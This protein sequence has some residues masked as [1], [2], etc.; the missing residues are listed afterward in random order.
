MAEPTGVLEGTT[1]HQLLSDDETR[2]LN[3]IDELRSQGVGKLLGEEGLPQ[4]IVCGDQSSGK[5]SVL[6]ALTRVR[7]P[8]KSSI[9]TTFPTELRLRREPE[10][11]ISCR[12]KAAA[13]RTSEEKERLARF[14]ESFDSPEKFPE[15]ITAAR[16]CMSESTQGNANAFF[17]DVLEVEVVGPKLAPLTIVDLPGLIHYRSTSSGD[18]DINLVTK[19]V[20]DYMKQSN[21]IILAVVSAHNDINNQIVLKHIKDIVPE[22]NRTLGIITKP[23]ELP[24][25]SEKEEEYLEYAR[26]NP[27]KFHYGWHVVRNRTYEEQASS[28]EERDAKEMNFFRDSNWNSLPRRE[29]GLG[30][31]GLRQKLSKMLLD[32]INL[33]LPSIVERLE[34]DLERSEGDLNRLGEPRS[35]T[36]DQKNYLS[37][38]SDTF[39]DYV[40]DALDGRYHRRSFFGDPFSPEGLEKRLRA[41]IRNLNDEF[42]SRM[43]TQGH[44]WHVVEE[45]EMLSESFRS[46]NLDHPNIISK[47]EFLADI[48]DALA[49]HERGNELPGLSNPLLVGSLFQQQSEP[50]ESIATAHLD[51][52]WEAVNEFLETLLSHLT[53][54]RTCNQLLI[55]VIDPAME[56]KRQVLRSKLQE[57]LVPHKHNPINV[58]PLFAHKIWSAK[59]E[60]ITRSVVEVVRQEYEGKES[61]GSLLSVDEMIGKIAAAD[62]PVDDKHGSN[63]TF[64]FMQAYY[65]MTILIFINN[66][67]S[68]AVE[69]CL[70]TK[71]PKIF[72]ST[73]IREMNDEKLELVASESRETRSEREHVAERVK[74]LQKGLQTLKQVHPG[75]RANRQTAKVTQRAQAQSSNKHDSTHRDL[76]ARGTSRP[77]KAPPAQLPTRMA[78]PSPPKPTSNQGSVKSPKPS[79]IGASGSPDG[80]LVGASS[81]KKPT[82]N[83][84]GIPPSGNR[85]PFAE[86]A[87]LG[88]TPFGTPSETTATRGLPFTGLGQT[89]TAGGFGTSGPFSTAGGFGQT[90]TLGRT[91]L[92]GASNGTTAGRGSPFEGFSQAFQ[93]PSPTPSGGLFGGSSQPIPSTTSI[94]SKTAETKSPNGSLFGARSQPLPTP[95]GSLFGGSPQPLPTPSG[96]HF[97]FNKTPE[98]TNPGIKPPETT[99]L[100]TKPP[101]TK[102]SETKTSE[103]K[104]PENKGTETELLILQEDG[105]GPAK[106][107]FQFLRSYVPRNMSF[108]EIRLVDYANDYRRPI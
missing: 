50:W 75:A 96:T 15:L 25:G 60:C 85:A 11:R 100:G 72:S 77:L 53:D 94:F 98:T 3:T 59:K 64:E 40:K 57:L 58:D 2:L 42:A 4:L 13:S 19:L 10:S 84:S 69:Q 95:S 102:T 92:F 23:D 103:T 31:D 26:T 21:S 14:Q 27:S 62:A 51:I 82:N 55:H 48:V 41:N 34:D 17:E 38:I 18:R 73:T 87:A 91:N 52:V 32:H 74:V 71:L 39:S 90:A 28:F 70:L 86:A 99:N 106:S 5:S 49:Y 108:E 79:D 20:Q 45:S 83:L 101:E 56:T 104:T 30:I 105:Y 37:D 81:Q 54:E 63:Q 33:S 97:N 89:G 78:S 46:Q 68:L 22:G 6:E 36:K 65:E 80:N 47:S 35:N 88:R 66:V 24:S 76:G 8:T 1:L 44:K 7:F 61:N 16:K 12:I 9:C 93:N 43:L 67:A 29:V 107:E